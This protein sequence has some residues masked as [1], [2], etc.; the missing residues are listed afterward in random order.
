M[1]LFRV[2][3]RL[4]APLGTPLT[5]GTLFGQLCWVKREAQGEK[6][7][8]A[9]LHRDNEAKLWALSDGFPKGFL[10]RPLVRP[11]PPSEDPK[12]ADERK[13]LKKRNFVT[14]KGFV[15]TRD[16]VSE[17]TLGG[18]LFASADRHARFAHNTI[19]RRTGSTL[20]EG[21]LYFLDEDW[22][23]SPPEEGRERLPEGVV[24]AGAERDVYVAAADGDGREIEDLFEALGETGYGRDATLGRGLWTV[25]SVTEDKELAAG[26]RGRLLSLSHGSVE[27]DMAELRCKLVAHYGKAGP[28]I[29]VEGGVS[30]FKKPLLLAAPG[31]T[32]SGE[33]ENQYGV[34]LRNVHPGRPEIV[35]NAFHV[36]IPFREAA[37]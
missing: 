16:R 20:E 36:A 35:H 10:P 27:R 15:K 4:Q 13:K 32:F 33:A 9:W 6:A 24:E 28:A 31:A 2:T 17:E 7:L 22:S 14:R 25:V 37:A 34:L 8:E 18:H 21:G 3:L 19:D 30:P 26:P 12:K 23:H 11:E 5:S 29:A 1:A